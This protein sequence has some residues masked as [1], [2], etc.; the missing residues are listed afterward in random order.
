MKSVCLQ[1]RFAETR[2]AYLK[3]KFADPRF[4]I[5]FGEASERWIR[6]SRKMEIAVEG[7]L[8]IAP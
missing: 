4:A 1:S 6:R 7:N 8:A 3:L 5:G 2:E